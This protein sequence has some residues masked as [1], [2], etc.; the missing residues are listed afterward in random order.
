MSKSQIV[1]GTTKVRIGHQVVTIQRG[2]REQIKNLFTMIFTAIL[3]SNEEVKLT[4]EEV[5]KKEVK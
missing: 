1:P 4:A 5:R 2:R 3:P